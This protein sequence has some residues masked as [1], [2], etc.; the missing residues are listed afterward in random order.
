MFS[1]AV[2]IG[3]VVCKWLLS[4][5]GT[6]VELYCKLDNVWQSTTPNGIKA[7]NY[8]LMSDW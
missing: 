6:V 8:P 5:D 2:G 3:Y 7:V 4:A 1:Y